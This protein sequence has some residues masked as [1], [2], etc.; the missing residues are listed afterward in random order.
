MVM[1]LFDHCWRWVDAVVGFFCSSY[2]AQE[3]FD[4]DLHNE[5]GEGSVVVQVLN[6]VL[7]AAVQE[8]KAEV[9][10]VDD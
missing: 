4:V 10:A 3:L 9:G 8:R 2:A 6:I 1:E 7:K 5:I